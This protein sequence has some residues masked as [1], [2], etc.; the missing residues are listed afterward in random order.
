MKDAKKT[1]LLVG[2]TAI[3]KAIASIKNRGEKL[4]ASIQLT[5]LSVIAHVDAHHDTTVADSLV[6]AMPKGGRRLALVEWLLANAKLRKLDGKDKADA[7]R[8]RT[9]AHFGFD[10]ARNTDM[11]GAEEK[12]W[13]EHKKEAPVATAFDAQAAVRKL[14]DRLKAGGEV[15]HKAEALAEARML[16]ELLETPSVVADA[17][18]QE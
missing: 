1:A 8:M 4:D 5:G 3:N 18:T 2:A 6:N 7:E 15:Q 10:K 13:Y 9:G 12:P 16:V 14:I 17:H 11:Q